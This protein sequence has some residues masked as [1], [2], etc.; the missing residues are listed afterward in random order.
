M[1][2]RRFL[3]LLLLSLLALPECSGDGPDTLRRA[4]R[5]GGPVVRYD[6]NARPFPEVPFPNDVATILDER[7]PT[8]RRL[9]ISEI[10]DTE[11]ERRTRRKLNRYPGFGLYQPITVAFEAPLDLA[12]IRARQVANRDPSDDV[13]LL[14]RLGDGPA[15]DTGAPAE[16]R[17]WPL[18]VGNGNFPLVLDR[19]CQYNFADKVGDY[20]CIPPEC[21]GEDPRARSSNLIFETVDEDTNGN[22][23]LDPYE[24]TDFD[25]RLDEPNTWSG[26]PSD[27]SAAAADDLVTFYEKETNTLVAQPLL[28]LHE[29]T[30]YAVVLT[31]HL[32]D[33]AGRPVESPFRGV[34]AADQVPALR[35][36]EELLPCY[37]MTLDDVAFA[38]TFTTGTPTRELLALREGLYGSG[39]FAA[40]A[41]AAP[42][43]SLRPLVARDAEDGVLPEKPYVLPMS[44]LQPILQPIAG[45]ILETPGAGQELVVDSAAIDY[46]V[47]GRFLTPYLMVDKDGRATPKHPDDLDEEFELDLDTGKVVFEPQ[48]VPFLCSIPKTTA[49]H[50]P[51]FPVALYGHGYSG[52]SFEIMGFAGR[53]ARAG[54]ALCAIEAPA[55][56]LVIP[57]DEVAIQQ[58][59]QTLLPIAKLQAFYDAYQGGRAR[60]IDN[61]GTIG[62]L[63]NGGDFWVTNV[64][65]VRDMLRQLILDQMQFVRVL[66]AIDGKRRGP[67]DVNGDGTPDL[68]GDFDGNGVP[69]LGGWID[70]DGD[71]RRGA[72]EKENPYFI[73]GQ[74]LGGI[75]SAILAAVEPAVRVGVPS[76]GAAGLTHVS[77]RS[78]NVGVP[79]AV[80]LSMMGPFVYF[81]PHL[82]EDGQPDGRVDV[83]HLVANVNFPG[84]YVFHVSDKIRPKD[85]VIVRN[86]RTGREVSGFA[87]DDLTFRLAV[88]VDAL[89]AGEKRD[90]LGLTDED[91]GPKEVSDA[92]AVLLGDPLVVVVLDGFDGP[93]R[94]VIDEVTVPFTYQGATWP[95]GAPVTA[96]VEG[97]GYG[98]N[99]PNFRRILA[100]AQMIIEPADP[101][102]YAPRIF[103]RPF[104]FPYETGDVKAYRDGGGRT[105]FVVVH[106]VGDSDVPIASGIA[107]ARTAG[108]VGLDEVDPRYG[109]T[110]NE[111]LLDNHVI[112]GVNRL[113]RYTQ[114]K[115]AGVM[116]PLTRP[117]SEWRCPPVRDG[118]E[119]RYRA[120][121]AAES[122]SADAGS[123]DGAA[124]E[125]E[126]CFY[127][128]VFVPCRPEC[129]AMAD[130]E[131]EGIFFDVDDLDGGTDRLILPEYNLD[132]PL[133]LALENEGGVF[134]LRIPYLDRYGSHGVPPSIPERAF[135]VNGFQTNQI[136]WLFESVLRTGKPVLSD[137][138]CLVDASC[139]FLEWE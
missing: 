96:L 7:S 97:F 34:A 72:D 64:F 55:H 33:E 80:L 43:E 103:E 58:L 131:L 120:F 130:A 69:D 16:R 71:G 112:E 87:T 118:E 91:N 62:D 81:R 31:K 12:N 134:G 101:A 8:G 104:E 114:R 79:E 98:R 20:M 111:V 82:G 65:H 45:Q 92:Q 4:V 108:I 132:P 106:S 47:D 113:N 115:Q 90:V 133:R 129:A 137:D 89:N 3:A 48:E 83:G 76:S 24:D 46:W 107:L 18:D 86:T 10:A 51:P 23:L 29:A 75:S 52:A 100:F 110:P 53:W 66:R 41:A 73:W 17:R 32:T 117:S 93:V 36:L 50:K 74:S 25:G 124:P 119:E 35:Q 94:E 14:V 59:L 125:G 85:R 122:C 136:L 42:P 40:L 95:V 44:M 138:P 67:T 116:C 5:A 63:D 9:N 27:D 1:R 6:L 78:T 84:R 70:A 102:V 22:G 30:T 2:I 61:S 26:A 54:I 56:G 109:R 105:S 19:P 123:C 57:E 135:D 49:T 39:P 15:C 60:D 127:D 37:G 128:D 38:W 13:I 68:L 99:S 139:P 28:S 77:S 126:A 88:K 21:E 121:Y 11:M